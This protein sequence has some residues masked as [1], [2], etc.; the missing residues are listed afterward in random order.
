MLPLPR[1]LQTRQ[2]KM[3][4]A[5]HAIMLNPHLD[6]LW[7]QLKIDHLL[8]RNSEWIPFN[9]L[10][11]L[12]HVWQRLEGKPRF[13]MM[14]QL[15][16][17]R[18]SKQ[19]DSFG[20]TGTRERYTMSSFTSSFTPLK[21]TRCRTREPARARFTFSSVARCRQQFLLL[22][23]GRLFRVYVS[24]LMSSIIHK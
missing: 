23:Q 1:E 13:M 16:R 19:T 7:W 8:R 17:A 18:N 15:L 9:V 22:S 5:M 2:R 4:D 3:H 10:C 24:S 21:R 20:S 6:A 11:F 14:N 12:N